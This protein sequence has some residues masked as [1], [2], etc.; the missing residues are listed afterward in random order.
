[1][2]LRLELPQQAIVG[3]FQFLAIERL[4]EPKE[5]Q[6]RVGEEVPID[7]GVRIAH[8]LPP[9]LMSMRITARMTM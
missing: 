5:C 9:S 8:S 1:M 3:P 2:L 4:G 7:G 6:R